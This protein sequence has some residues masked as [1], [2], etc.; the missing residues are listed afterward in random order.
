LDF[1]LWAWLLIHGVTELS[2]VVLAAAAGFRL[3]WT[4]VF[5]GRLSRLD[6]LRL[7]SQTAAVAMAGVVVMLFSAGLLEG[8]GRQLIQAPWARYV[9][10]ATTALVWGL[11]LFGP[12]G[13]KL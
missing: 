12:L 4:L 3:G 13:R 2:A 9:V 5:P 11:Y 6:A 8:F 7:Q 1:E 10:A